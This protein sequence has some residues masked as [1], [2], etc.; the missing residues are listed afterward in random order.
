MNGDIIPSLFELP[1]ISSFV[2]N[3]SEKLIDGSSCIVLIPDTMSSD[4]LYQAIFQQL[5]KKSEWI[6]FLDP[7]YF[8]ADSRPLTIL[9]T[10]I[11]IKWQSLNVARTISKMHLHA[12][13]PE[14]SQD[15]ILIENVGKMKPDDREQWLDLLKLWADLS[16][17]LKDR[18]QS[19]PALCVILPASLCPKP[20]DETLFHKT[21][22]WWGI[23]TLLEL[24]LLSQYEKPL[25]E[26]SE[27]ALWREHILPWLCIG[28]FPLFAELWNVNR[29]DEEQIANV[30]GK[31]AKKRS[32][33]SSHFN[34]FKINENFSKNHLGFQH[35]I[36]PKDIFIYW[37]KGLIGYCPVY[38]ISIST[39]VLSL[40]NRFEEINH[41]IWIAQ[42]EALF[43]VLD[44]CRLTLCDYLN[45]EFGSDWP[46][47][48]LQPLDKSE[49]EY[50]FK[51][52]FNC[53]YGHMEAVINNWSKLTNIKKRYGSYIYKF[54]KVRNELAH[55][56]PLTLLQFKN[57]ISAVNEFRNEL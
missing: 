38:G 34:D 1:S 56:R 41:R 48:Y 23:P 6:E 25:N 50:L 55:N 18:G 44:R 22:Y 35:R 33:D 47:T 16:K 54:R 29:I 11:G 42:C 52:S 36:P 43:P 37:A 5:S 15:V 2:D 28:D 31:I 49:S 26:N 39:V 40:M 10:V 12:T 24:K 19:I 4:V 32:W 45:Q 3:I 14:I 27:L 21:F 8:F 57:F 20:S 9:E 30:I 17:T 7:Y 51:S 13:F 46:I 53:Q